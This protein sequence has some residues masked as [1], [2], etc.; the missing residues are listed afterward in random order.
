MSGSVAVA[1]GPDEV[2][3]FAVLALDHAGVDRCGEARVVQLDGEVFALRLAGG[4][5]PGRAE[6]RG[7]C[8]RCSTWRGPGHRAPTGR[9]RAATSRPTATSYEAI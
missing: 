3:G 4:L 9:T 7:S 2:V 8:E 5:L 6:F 1:G